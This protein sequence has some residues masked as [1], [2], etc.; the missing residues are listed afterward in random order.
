MGVINPKQKDFRSFKG[1]VYWL[2]VIIPLASFSCSFLSLFPACVLPASFLIAFLLLDLPSFSTSFFHTALLPFLSFLGCSDIFFPFFL[3]YFHFP[4]LPVFFFL[5]LPCALPSFLLVFLFMCHFFFVTLLPC[6]FA[7]CFSSVLD[8]L[9]FSILFF[10]LFFCTLSFLLPFASIF[11]SC[12]ISSFL[13]FVFASFL[14]LLLMQRSGS[15]LFQNVFFLKLSNLCPSFVPF[16]CSSFLFFL[17]IPVLFLLPFLLILPCV[18]PPFLSFL[19]DVLLF[20]SFSVSRFCRFYLK[21]LYRRVF[22]K[23]IWHFK[24]SIKDWIWKI[25]VWE[26][27]QCFYEKSV[28]IIW[29]KENCTVLDYVLKKYVALYFFTFF[30]RN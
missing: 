7:S 19:P 3:L 20:L 9:I 14:F 30:C 13:P 11:R 28:E 22:Y 4:M 6:F 18:I 10:I 23:F 15:F 16:F 27:M 21:S 12:V 8:S 24:M 29:H 5:L 26:S 1:F 2:K 25:W 17:Q